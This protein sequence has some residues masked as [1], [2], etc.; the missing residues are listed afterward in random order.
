MTQL[1]NIK[2]HMTDRMQSITDEVHQIVREFLQY[3]PG[4]DD[5]LKLPEHMDFV[6]QE[7]KQRMQRVPIHVYIYAM[8]QTIRSR[9]RYTLKDGSP[10]SNSGLI[11]SMLNVY[12]QDVKCSLE[13]N[14]TV[15]NPFE[16]RALTDQP[17]ISDWM[18]QLPLQGDVSMYVPGSTKRFIYSDYLQSIDEVA[19]DFNDDVEKC[20]D[21]IV[22]IPLGIAIKSSEFGHQNMLLV[23]KMRPDKYF[24]LIY[25]PHGH[26]S[27]I[28]EGVARADFLSNLQKGL[29]KRSN[30]YVFVPLETT[31]CPVGLQARSGDTVG[32]CVM[33]SNFW[34]YCI[35]RCFH[36]LIRIQDVREFQDAVRSVESTILNDVSRESLF[37]MVTNFAIRYSEQFWKV[38]QLNSDQ[39]R[40]FDGRMYRVLKE[41]KPVTIPSLPLTMNSL[42]V[43]KE[44]RFEPND[45]SM[46]ANDGDECRTSS[47]CQSHC[48]HADKRV[49]VPVDLNH[50]QLTYEEEKLATSEEFT[51]LI[52]PLFYHGAEFTLDRDAQLRG[53]YLLDILD[54]ANGDRNLVWRL[55][56]FFLPQ[57]VIHHLC[58]GTF[59]FNPHTLEFTKDLDDE[60]SWLS[61]KSSQDM[62]NL[63]KQMIYRNHF[64]C[65]MSFICVTLQFETRPALPYHLFFMSRRDKQVQLFAFNMNENQR[66][67]TPLNVLGEQLARAMHKVSPDGYQVQW[68]GF[69]NLPLEGLDSSF[70]QTVKHLI[71][72]LAIV[73]FTH[74]GDRYV[75]AEDALR[76]FIR[77]WSD[78]WTRYQTS[79]KQIM[80][81]FASDMIDRQTDMNIPCMEQQLSY[82]REEQ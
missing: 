4:L 22:A 81:K 57:N 35:L 11:F 55:A 14:F 70:A 52:S 7:N 73:F 51:S 33:F 27:N 6:D 64:A 31:S 9:V 42:Y 72:G 28:E 20:P 63:A 65:L 2:K 48:C 26:Q 79:L 44:E 43:E 41:E 78:S 39:M 75:N 10:F 68:L 12:T 18:H 16:D 19:E 29:S 61:I 34:F 53:K 46:L 62:E 54:C 82:L 15:V 17:Q 71:N 38:V 76:D 40:E 3:H 5:Q 60:D 32:Y 1:Y 8:F 25:E 47:D 30:K 74:F 67:L 56:T 50:G 59:E 23:M 66:Y 58:N 36:L 69:V 45:E 49:C 77:V 24:V 13:I 21:R 80:C 37:M